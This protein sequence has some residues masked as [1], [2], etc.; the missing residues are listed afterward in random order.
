[1]GRKRVLI[2]LTVLILLLVGCSEK[3]VSAERGER[4][5]GSFVTTDLAGN[6][7]N[8]E[9]F[10][11]C[12]LTMVNI[13]ATSCN[14]C[15]KELP[16]LTRLQNAWGEEFQV[17]GIVVDAADKNG[18]LLPDKIETAVS[19][20]DAAEGDFLHLLPSPSLNKA[21]L[22]GVQAT[23]E[24]VFIDENGNQIGNRYFGAKSEKQWKRIVDT[25][26]EHLEQAPS[27]S[28]PHIFNQMT[29]GITLGVSRRF[30]SV[31]KP[32]CF[33]HTKPLLFW[34]FGVRMKVGF[35]PA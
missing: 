15:I 4:I 3:P 22:N 26:L 1:M 19:I 30:F 17:I 10:S 23:P 21:Y 28:K 2:C 8:E 5:F 12:T 6:T 7:V 14:P 11:R 24:T 35:F 9:I 25:L 29:D 27:F 13:W 33:S 31:K 34:G 16:E 20:A 18:T 32:A